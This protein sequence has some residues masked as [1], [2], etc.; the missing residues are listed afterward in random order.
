MNFPRIDNYFQTAAQAFEEIAARGWHGFEVTLDPEEDL[1]WHD[2]DAVVFVLGVAWLA[3]FAA[4]GPRRS[5]P[6]GGRCST[7]PDRSDFQPAPPPAQGDIVA[8]IRE[9]VH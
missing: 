5:W 7:T 2:F 3:W 1:H 6:G 9:R 8:V 4:A